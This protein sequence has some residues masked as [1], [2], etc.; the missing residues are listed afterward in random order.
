M[1]RTELKADLTEVFSKFFGVEDGR[2]ICSVR[3]TFLELRH[4]HLL[5]TATR[6]LPRGKDCQD[7]EA[8]VEELSWESSSVLVEIMTILEKAVEN[9]H[10][11]LDS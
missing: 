3:K 8:I 9:P 7:L 4:L 11:A 10:S 5:R 6:Y 1:T 2:L